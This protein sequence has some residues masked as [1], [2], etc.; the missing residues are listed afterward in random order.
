MEATDQINA[1]VDIKSLSDLN[2]STDNDTKSS[3]EY[4]TVFTAKK[5][6][7]LNDLVET[8]KDKGAEDWICVI[9]SDGEII[10]GF[11]RKPNV[12]VMRMALQALMKGIGEISV[13]AGKVYLENLIIQ[14]LSDP[15]LYSQS[16]PQYVFVA[17]SAEL[18]CISKIQILQ[19]DVKKK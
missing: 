17:P 16:E 12:I 10:F 2:I 15:R 19:G 6:T 13:E 7:L 3:P 14:N 5:E 4:Q 8:Y 11:L 18:A 1:C 9:G